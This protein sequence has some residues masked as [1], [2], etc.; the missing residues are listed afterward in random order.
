MLS[1]DDIYRSIGPK[2]DGAV[3]EHDVYA[4]KKHVQLTLD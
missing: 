2:L 1:F 4:R 3:R